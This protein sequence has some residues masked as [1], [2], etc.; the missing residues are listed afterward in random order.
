MQGC[1]V[2]EGGVVNATY[3]TRFKVGTEGADAEGVVTLSAHSEGAHATL[4][5]EP[6]SAGSEEAAFDRL[7]DVLDGIAK[8]LRARGE[9]KLGVPFYG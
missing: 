7:A 1:E 4:S 8:A 2:G 9:P 3:L 5:M 6:A